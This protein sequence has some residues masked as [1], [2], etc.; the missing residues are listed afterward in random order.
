MKPDKP[1][2]LSGFVVHLYF[3]RS[4]HLPPFWLCGRTPSTPVQVGCLLCGLGSIVIVLHAPEEKDPK[5]VMEIWE[6]AQQPWFMLYGAV[7]IVGSIFLIVHTAP[8]HG[9]SNILVYLAICSLVGSMS[10]QSAKALGIAMK[11]SFEGDNQF[12]YGP[13]W[14]FLLVVACSAVT[15]INYLNK[16]LNTFNTAYVSPIYYVM[17]TTLVIM[18]SGIMYHEW[19]GLDSRSIVSILSGF[20]VTV[21]GVFLLKITEGLDP[22]A[23]IGE[24]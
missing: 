2:W 8:R 18:A 5:S 23:S 19:Q 3:V 12:V 20:L 4:A 6:M 10:V 16:S 22:S 14:V 21:A 7:V 11:L 15:Q 24:V 17:F 13:T 1:V 9:N